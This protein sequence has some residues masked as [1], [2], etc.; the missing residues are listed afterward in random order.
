MPK[1]S[2][3]T[4]LITA[5]LAYDTTTEWSGTQGSSPLGSTQGAQGV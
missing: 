5:Y 1:M 3:K 4:A 2:R